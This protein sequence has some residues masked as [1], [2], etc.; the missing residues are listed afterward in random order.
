MADPLVVVGAG[1]FGRETLDVADALNRAA[2]APV[3]HVTG[4]VD[5]DPSDANRQRLRDLGVEH[6][7]PVS[8]LDPDRHPHVVVA[9]GDPRVRRRV[10]QRLTEGGFAHA[11]LVHPGAT[12]GSQFVH[13]VGL[14]VCAG[15]SIGTN[16]RL[17]D[18]VHLNAHAVIGHDT[19]LDDCV[20]VNPNATI[21][22]EC[23]IE[24]HV[25]VGASA[26]VL[27]GLRVGSDSVVGAAACVTRDVEA[28]AVVTGVPAR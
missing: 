9:I 8:S 25:L 17:G 2:D 3:W 20:S 5:D 11:S 6:L 18:H 13:G 28:Q 4:V 27:Q 7:G 14:V 22:G 10:A 21:S 12:V 24:E 16:V 23:S 26:T 1:G 15:V 19:R